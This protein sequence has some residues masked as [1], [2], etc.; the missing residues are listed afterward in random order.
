MKVQKSSIRF[1]FNEKQCQI[2]FPSNKKQLIKSNYRHRCQQL[3][4]S[5]SKWRLHPPFSLS[6]TVYSTEQTRWPWPTGM[7]ICIMRSESGGQPSP[8]LCKYHITPDWTIRWVLCKSDITSSNLPIKTGKFHCWPAFSSWKPL[9]LT[10]EKVS[11][12]FSFCAC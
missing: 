6:A 3:C 4:Q 8:C 11:Y 12:S 9:S 1:S 5:C 7:P 2:I 10:R